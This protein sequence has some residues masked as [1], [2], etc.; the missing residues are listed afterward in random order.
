MRPLRF[1]QRPSSPQKLAWAVGRVMQRNG[2][3]WGR[4]A[5]QRVEDRYSWNAVTDAYEKLFQAS[6][7]EGHFQ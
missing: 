6:S 4:R 1:R 2:S 3:C 7:F 5:M